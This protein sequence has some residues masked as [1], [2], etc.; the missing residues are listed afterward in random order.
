M[1]IYIYTYMYVYVYVC[2]HTCIERSER[3]RG[4]DMAAGG[5]TCR[6]F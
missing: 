3:E 6:A 5:H 1:C 2:I 4:V